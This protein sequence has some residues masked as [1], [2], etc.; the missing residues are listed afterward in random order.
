VS[1]S[2]ISQAC[3][4]VECYHITDVSSHYTTVTAQ[5]L[6]VDLEADDILSNKMVQVAFEN[7]YL[8]HNFLSLAALHINHLERCA[9]NPRTEFLKLAERHHGAALSTFRTMVW[10]INESNF[11]P[12]LLSAGTLFPYSC[13]LSIAVSDNLDHAFETILSNMLLTR[14]MR[15]IMS[16]FYHTMKSSDLDKLI[17]KDVQDLNW[18]AA[19]PRPD[20][21]LPQLRKF[22]D[23]AHQI[24]NPDIVE[25]YSQAID[26]LELVFMRAS[27]FSLSPSSSLLRIWIHLV[28]DRYVQLLSD[29]QPGAL[30][31]FAYFA[32][33][34][35]KGEFF[36]YMEGMAD[37]VLKIVDAH[38]PNEWAPWIEWPKEQ[39]RTQSNTF[40]AK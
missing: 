29:K 39:V 40:D 2:C 10:D 31:I 13:G 3:K 25:A 22:A 37:L 28:P 20:V 34:L 24:Y 18:E 5:S 15:P 36:W 6:A 30:I 35:K 19:K 1:L 21:Q 26:I 8:L 12:I 4:L 9:A 38:I 11:T 32:V 17:P 23:V 33:L 16:N 7:P 27:K 14:K